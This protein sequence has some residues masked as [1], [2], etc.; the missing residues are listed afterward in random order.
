MRGG[1]IEL[2]IRDEGK[3][4]NQEI[5]SKLNS[6]ASVGVGFRGMQERVRLIGGKL[7]VHPNPNGNGTSVLVTLP[8]NEEALAPSQNTALNPDRVGDEVPNETKP[9][10]RAQDL[11]L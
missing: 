11:S 3:G 9:A 8:L 5:Q 10:V 1:K 6:G 2:E 4:I 7:T